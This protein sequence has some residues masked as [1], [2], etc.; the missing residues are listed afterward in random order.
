[1]G[2]GLGVGSVGAGG[3]APP[4]PPLDP[5]E[6]PPVEPPPRDPPPPP[7]APAPA[8]DDD[9]VWPGP[10]RVGDGLGALDAAAT[11]VEPDELISSADPT[12]PGEPAVCPGDAGDAGGDALAR[13]ST[14]TAATITA[15]TSSH[16]SRADDLDAIGSHSISG[17]A[18]GRDA[19]S[20]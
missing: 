9:D 17:P 3:V 20:T 12:G 2:L 11:A 10:P 15:G 4:A 7:A 14:A 8:G 1:M 6:P 16:Q 19:E 18:I 13:T 5:P